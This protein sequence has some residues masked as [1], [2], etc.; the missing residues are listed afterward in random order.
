MTQMTSAENVDNFKLAVRGTS[1]NFTIELWYYAGRSYASMA[2][3]EI[4]SGDFTGRTTKFGWTYHSS[5]G[6]P[7]STTEPTATTTKN[8]DWYYAKHTQTA[9]TDP[10]A[11]GTALSFIDSI[12]QNENGEVTVTKK[13]VS[14]ATTSEHGL[15]SATDKTKLD[16]IAAGA[17]ANVQ[18]DWNQTNS[19]ADDF[20]KNKPYYSVYNSTEALY[21]VCTGT[22]EAGGNGIA[23]MS[24]AS[25]GAIYG[26]LIWRNTPKLFLKMAEGTYPSTQSVKLYVSVSESSVDVYVRCGNYARL[27]VAPLI[28]NPTSVVNFDHFGETIDSIP[29]GATEITPVWVANSASSSGTAPVKVDAYGALTACTVDTAPTDSSTNL[30]TSGGVKSALDLKSDKD[31][32]VEIGDG[33][34]VGVKPGA[35]N[36]IKTC[37][38]K[39]CSFNVGNYWSINF[40]VSAT[41]RL[42]DDGVYEDKIIEIEGYNGESVGAAREVRICYFKKNS[43]SGYGNIFYYTL[44]NSVV[45][46]YVNTASKPNVTQF[47]R[48]LSVTNQSSITNLTWYSSLAAGD[49]PESP[50]KFTECFPAVKPGGSSSVP[51]YVDA[52]GEIKACTDDFVHDGDVA[53]TYSSTGS[54]PVNGTAVA[55]ALGTLDVTDTAVSHQF[56]TAVSETDGKVSIARVQPVIADVDGLQTALDGKE[57]SITWMTEQEARSIWANAKAAVAAS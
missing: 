52:N 42:F 20:I 6:A 4:E 28:N 36:N 24:R 45:T 7:D 37:Y 14:D 53:S 47:L 50:T 51:V 2:I 16:G 21:K 35:P 39:V 48:L 55:A 32:H 25:N 34:W 29:E 19:S 17:E 18:A 49:Q 15:M 46:I 9:V 3:R 57:G 30:V 22:I 56:V 44:S 40:R 43:T 31:G 38:W 41:N 23:I 5:S 11:S 13:T 12:T 54:D 33:D 8:I 1:E 26:E 27:K 10:T